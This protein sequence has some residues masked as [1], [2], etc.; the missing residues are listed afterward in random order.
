MLSKGLD[1]S[2]VADITELS[3]EEIR[4]EAANLKKNGRH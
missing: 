2:F 3:L 4:S 1:E